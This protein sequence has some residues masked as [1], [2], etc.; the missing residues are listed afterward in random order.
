MLENINLKK[1]LNIPLKGEAVLKVKKVIRPESIAIKP[2]EFK[3][4]SP[5]LLVREGDKVLK[6]S[7]IISDKKRPDILLV[8]PASGTIKQIVRGEKRKLLSVIIAVDKEDEAIDF[9]KK[10]VREL[11]NEEI[12]EHLLKSGLWL[13]LIE[14]PYG[15]VANPEITPKSIFISAFNTAPL[16]A[17]TDFIAEN[18]FNNIQIAINA[19]NKLSNGGVHLSI[20]EEN[21]MST[22][23]HKL[24]NV[25]IHTIGGKKHPAGNVGVQISNISPIMK[26]E[27]VWTITPQM[28][29]AIGKL[30]TTGKYDLSRRIAI[31]GPEASEPAYIESIPGL[32]M[33]EIKEFYDSSKEIRFISG[34]CLSGTNIGAEGYLNFKDNQITLL[35][36]GR[37]REWFGW[38]KPFRCKKFTTSKSYL[39]WLIRKKEYSLNTNTNGGP[40]AFVATGIY[41]DVLPM[42]IF[43]IYLTKAC[44]AKD[45]DKMEKFGI[46]EVL[47]EDLALCE[48]IDPSKNEIQ[49]IIESGIDLMIKEMA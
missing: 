22:A 47:P 15:V 10:N 20:S 29:I 33:S 49:A 9:G 39:S 35:S 45:I 7:P 5:R 4:L 42:D 34:D 40:R 41:E 26:G 3:G 19:L 27:I 37:N 14:R 38:I 48:F 2:T 24:E 32:P 23:F 31:T 28:L 16:A 6:G 17:D 30:F 13:G 44:L 1:G 8:S 36:E 12:K 11:S 46:Y 21:C 25:V 18:E 43:P